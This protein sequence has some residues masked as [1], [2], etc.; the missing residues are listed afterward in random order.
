MKYDDDDE[1]ELILSNEQVKLYM[2]GEEMQKLNI[3][4]N[5][6]MNVNIPD[7]NQLIG[8]AAMVDESQELEPGEII[9]AKL[10]GE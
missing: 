7:Y 1:E 4:G 3:E 10:S 5:K 2:S 6:C 8:L 9:W